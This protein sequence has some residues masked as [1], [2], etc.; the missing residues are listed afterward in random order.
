MSNIDVPPNKKEN[1]FLKKTGNFAKGASWGILKGLTRSITFQGIRE[2]RKNNKEFKNIRNN[3]FEKNNERG[4]EEYLNNFLNSHLDRKEERGVRQ[5][6]LKAGLEISTE[7]INSEKK[8]KEMSLEKLKLLREKTKEIKDPET[9]KIIAGILKKNRKK[10][11]L[12][13]EERLNL[14]TETLNKEQ[15]VKYTELAKES[16]DSLVAYGGI[17]AGILTGGGALAGFFASRKISLLTTA[18]ADVR[19]TALETEP[20]TS[21]DLVKSIGKNTINH[22]KQSKKLA[23]LFSDDESKKVEAQKALQSVGKIAQYTLGSAVFTDFFFLDSTIRNSILSADFTKDTSAVNNMLVGT[24]EASDGSI[25]ESSE[26]GVGTTPSKEDVEI[27]KKVKDT[28][29]LADTNNLSEKNI[30]TEQKF[31]YNQTNND[32]FVPPKEFM[33]EKVQLNSYTIQSGDNLW[34]VLRDTLLKG[35]LEEELKTAGIKDSNF[36]ENSGLSDAQ[37]E[38]IVGNMMDKIELNPQSFGISS[39]Q[40]TELRIGDKIEFQKLFDEVISKEITIA[41]IEH[42]NLMSRSAE[43]TTEQL[44]NI[45]T[46]EI[47]YQP[48]QSKTVIGE[49]NSQSSNEKFDN[50]VYVGRV[51]GEDFNVHTETQP[52]M[53]TGRIMPDITNEAPFPPQIVTGEVSPQPAGAEITQVTA[54]ANQVVGGHLVSGVDNTV[55]MGRVSESNIS[56][57]T[58]TNNYSLDEVLPYQLTFSNE[59]NSVLLKPDAN[60]LDFKNTP[61]NENTFGQVDIRRIE[62]TFL[63]P[64]FSQI[65]FTKGGDTVIIREMSNGNYALMQNNQTLLNQP[66]TRQGLAEILNQAKDKLSQIENTN[67]NPADKI[68]ESTR[69]ELRRIE[70][71]LKKDF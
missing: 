13:Q 48:D 51:A 28:T 54:E 69:A 24:N 32:P 66:Q 60:L 12:L 40:I 21:L 64:S 16:V 3:V 11:N 70:Q 20:Q 57:S 4:L 1:S 33:T 41:D 2:A 39:G 42:N 37:I 15:L 55:Y 17:T 26:A 19:T 45:K 43:L 44:E 49:V 36:G 30:I 7:S 10:T 58:V 38:N 52:Q 29:S 35:E 56:E 67:T 5:K 6:D 34:S 25:I 53:V 71:N 14:A 47:N 50:K 23:N 9:R 63:T 18:L 68:P 27:D 65:E 61:F 46:A 31:E 22:F 59:I 8:Q 62:G